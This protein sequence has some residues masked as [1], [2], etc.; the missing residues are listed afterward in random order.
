M[1]FLAI[2]FSIDLPSEYFMVRIAAIGD[3]H[4]REAIPSYLVRDIE[5][6]HQRADVLVVTGDI[7]NFG[8]IAEVELA[9]ELFKIAQLPIIAVL[10]NHDRRTMR[11]RAFIKTLERAGVTVLNGTTVVFD[12]GVR[13]GFAGVGGSGGGFWPEGGPD[14]L[15]SR[16]SQALAVRARREGARLEKA[17]SSLQTDIKVVVTHYAPTISTL[18]NEP[19]AKYWMLGN[20]ELE[21]VI[22]RHDVDLVLHGHAHHGNAVGKTVGGTLVRNVAIDVV[23]GF[24]IH[25]LPIKHHPP[26]PTGQWMRGEVRP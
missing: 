11:L 16:A 24:V 26:V 9:A 1:H 14:T 7:T 21:K 17:L 18:G 3:L 5:R 20:C 22:D 19:P 10:G 23:G 13:V 15:P 25:E 8:R 2:E 12:R 6:I 4:I